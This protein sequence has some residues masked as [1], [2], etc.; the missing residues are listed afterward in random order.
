MRVHFYEVGVSREGSAHTMYETT[1][2]IT[3]TTVYDFAPP[4]Y[5]RFDGSMY[6]A[7][8]SCFDAETAST[9]CFVERHHGQ[10]YVLD[11]AQVIVPAEDDPA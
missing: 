7:V 2:L 10:L 3:S 4:Q 8:G 11:A 9:L 1:R 6:R 5:V